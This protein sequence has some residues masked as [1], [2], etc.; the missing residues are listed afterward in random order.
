MPEILHTLLADPWGIGVMCM[1][2][3]LLVFLGQCGA[4]AL[5]ERRRMTTIKP[6]AEWLAGVCDE[7]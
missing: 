6:R 3:A 1:F 7:E 5:I 4:L 2:A